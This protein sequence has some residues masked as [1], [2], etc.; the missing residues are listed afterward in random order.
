MKQNP[1]RY[2]ALSYER[3]GK[4]YRS[5]RNECY[6]CENFRKH[7]EYLKSKRKFLVGEKITSFQELM[8]QTW[9]FWGNRD[10]SMHIEVVKSLQLRIVINNLEKGKFYR[11]IRK[12]EE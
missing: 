10:K 2:C 12:M 6:E 11:A 7:Q 3:N 1:C 9:I 4:H 5:Y 8:E